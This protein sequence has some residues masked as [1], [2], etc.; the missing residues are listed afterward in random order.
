MQTAKFYIHNHQTCYLP[1]LHFIWL[2]EVNICKSKVSVGEVKNSFWVCV[3]VY[4]CVENGRCHWGVLAQLAA[5]AA[6]WTLDVS[7]V[8]V[9]TSLLVVRG[10]EGEGRCSSSGFKINQSGMRPLGP[11]GFIHTEERSLCSLRFLVIRGWIMMFAAHSCG[12]VSAGGLPDVNN[13]SLVLWM[14]F[15]A[16]S[17]SLSSHLN[18]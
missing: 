8:T 14:V 18:L 2:E 7:C 11:K 4:W 9:W 13:R 1:A 16:S 6:A 15:C 17:C 5:A 10:G 12:R 3:E